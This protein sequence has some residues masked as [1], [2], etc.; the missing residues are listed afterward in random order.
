MK[1]MT[2]R[3]RQITDP[4][5][6]RQILDKSKY[7]HLGLSVNDEPYVVPMNYGY[8]LEDGKLVLY[9]HSAVKG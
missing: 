4:E 9:L 1:G 6:I 3:E 2:K 7:L 8:I 5:Q